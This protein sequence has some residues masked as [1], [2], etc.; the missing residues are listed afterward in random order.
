[1]ENDPI[2]HWVFSLEQIFTWTHGSEF[3]FSG[4][5][6]F[7]FAWRSWDLLGFEN[8]RSINGNEVVFSQVFLIMD[9]FCLS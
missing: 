6:K 5:E 9:W 7:P 1:M 8:I 4:V 2:W 3:G